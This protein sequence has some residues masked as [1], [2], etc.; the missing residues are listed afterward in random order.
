MNPILLFRVVRGI[1]P[2]MGPA[3]GYE[4]PFGCPF[5]QV[6]QYHAGLYLSCTNMSHNSFEDGATLVLPFRIGTQGY[7]RKSDGARFGENSQDA[8]DMEPDDTF[9]DVYQPG[10]QPFTE[11]H[12]VRLI[13][14]LRNWF[15]MVQNGDLK[16]GA[17]EAAGGI[18]VWR[19]ADTEDSWD[20]VV[21]PFTW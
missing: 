1:S 5:S 14:I 19:K 21:I 2:C 11:M 16:V 12:G 7:A 3:S 17:D 8:E 13:G 10:H 18:D 4:C 15:E 6:E 9:A 20:N